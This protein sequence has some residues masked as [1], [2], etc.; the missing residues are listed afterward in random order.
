MNLIGKTVVVTGAASGLGRGI[1]EWFLREK[2]CRIV[3]L[4]RNAEGL[5]GLVSEMGCDSVQVAAVDITSGGEVQAAI[6]AGHARFGSIDVCLNFAGV[7][8]PIRIFDPKTGKVDL[9][10][11][12]SAVDVNLA[13]TFN[14]MAHC[15]ERMRHNEPG[16]DGERGVVP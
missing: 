15:A 14:V 11:F 10:G 5:A 4:D 13:G 12:K 7:V 3:A 9:D 6:G 8:A 16:D 2:Q 1:V